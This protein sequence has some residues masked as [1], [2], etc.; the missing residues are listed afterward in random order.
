MPIDRQLALA[1]L[2]SGVVLIGAGTT[3]KPHGATPQ[4]KITPQVPPVS[5]ANVAERVLSDTTQEP[6]PASNGLEH[7]GVLTR[8][9]KHLVAREDRAAWGP[10]I[11][12]VRVDLQRALTRPPKRRTEAWARWLFFIPYSVPTPRRARVRA[13]RAAVTS[14]A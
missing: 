3:P 1:M 8:L 5:D 10:W 7:A 6:A 11:E 12:L 13:G 14:S 4:S 9:L 2:L